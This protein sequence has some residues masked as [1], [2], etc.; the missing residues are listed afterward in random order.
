MEFTVS[1]N[2][3]LNALQKARPF[4][5]KGELFKEFL[6]EVHPSIP[7]TMK[8]HAISTIN[9]E[10]IIVLVPLE[11][12][13]FG[14]RTFSV[15]ADDI[16]KPLKTLDDQPL[17]FEISEYQLEVKHSCGSFRMPLGKT[18]NSFLNDCIY[19][20]FDM[21]CKDVRH[22]R[23]EA[24]GLR[25]IFN[26]CSFAMA[27][28]EL[29]PAMNGIYFNFTSKFTDYVA[30]DGHRLVR[31]RK[32]PVVGDLNDF[33]FI[34][35]AGTVCRLNRIIP[36]VGDVFMDIHVMNDYKSFARMIVDDNTVVYFQPVESRYPNYL[37]VIPEKYDIEVVFERR[38]LLRSLNR[39]S[40]FAG[41][42][43]ALRFK[44]NEGEATLEVKDYDYSLAGTET[45]PYENTKDDVRIRE[46][47]I[48]Y[49][50]PNLSSILKTLT[51]EKV[52]FHF[53]DSAHASVMTPQPQPEVEDI[54]MLMMPML[55]SE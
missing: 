19:S 47:V 49:K 33:G 27:K 20:D 44:L 29:R 11:K 26:V 8:V 21:G 16:L 45:L 13:S 14:S 55:L 53:T 40:Y 25:H 41:N 42:N 35:Q 39:L 52:V 34:I 9:Q 46:F 22:P 7:S 30:S 23:F 50:L 2:N 38:K 3:L 18:D 6:F 24:P 54:L 4:I 5:T 37:N 12:T 48:G 17:S 32:A 51:A 43:K 28:G 15:F 36:T 31:I 1:R 10:H